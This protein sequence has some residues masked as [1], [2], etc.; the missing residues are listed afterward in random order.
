M[1]YYIASQINGGLN[2][3]YQNL[4]SEL[5]IVLN[6]KKLQEKRRI[7]HITLKS[8]FETEE[9]SPLEDF[10]GDLSSKREKSPIY[11]EGFGRFGSKTIFLKVNPSEKFLE[12]YREIHY[13]FKN[14]GLESSIYDN[15]NKV[16]HIT[17]AN[18][19]LSKEEIMIVWDHL[20]HKKVNQEY[21][22]DNLCIFQNEDYEKGNIYKRL[23]F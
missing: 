17:L 3:Y 4:V 16:F 21:L 5:S 6:S 1:K 9:I 23:E 13:F 7:P 11:I 22:I 8:A 12:F 15:E 2:K 20:T 18:K 14:K 10:L 19:E